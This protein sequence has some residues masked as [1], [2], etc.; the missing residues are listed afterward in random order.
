MVTRT[1][2]IY[3]ARYTLLTLTNS[4]AE[5]GVTATP[6]STDGTNAGAINRLHL[7]GTDM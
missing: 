7:E 3:G 4:S 2:I 5:A 1:S 6:P